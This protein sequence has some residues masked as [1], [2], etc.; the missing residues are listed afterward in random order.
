MMWTQVEITL[1][2]ICIGI[3]VCRP[4]WMRI[5]GK[6]CIRRVKSGY[7]RH[8]EPDEA[9][10]SHFA[11]HTVGGTPMKKVKDKCPA[12]KSPSSPMV[13]LLT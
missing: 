7:V 4:L 6:C 13:S 1:T 12:D 8:N 10:S 5:L 9:A 3:P 11:L 2:M